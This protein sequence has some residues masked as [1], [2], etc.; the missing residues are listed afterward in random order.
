M[1]KRSLLTIILT[2]FVGMISAQTL[3]IEHEGYIYQNGE[4]IICQYDE[5]LGEYAHHLQIRNLSDNE[6]N[7]V[8]EQEVLNTTD[9]VV[10]M[11]CWGLCMIPQTNP[12]ASNPVAIP[13][14]TLSNEDFSVHVIIPETVVDVIK[15][16]YHVYDEANPDEK[17]DIVALAGQTANTP[18]YSFNLGQ[19]YPNPA[20]SQVHFDLQCNDNVEVVVYNLLGQEVKSQF[21]S[22][23]Q[24]RVKI[25]V[26]DLQPGI[27][28]C[29]FSV[30]GAIVKTEKFIEKR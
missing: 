13:A 3:Q 28:F 18:E 7:V 9:D 23:R 20:T 19:A 4:T 27:Y 2:A 11:F 26:D 24:N 16:I 22:G 29:R 6:V 15:V 14:Q 25:A 30:N 5:S 21:I 8:V 17:V 1:L 10:I 12:F